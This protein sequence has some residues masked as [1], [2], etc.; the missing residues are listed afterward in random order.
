MNQVYCT[1]CRHFKLLFE[2]ITK[3]IPKN[4]EPCQ[5]CFP[6]E[7][8]DSRPSSERPYYEDEIVQA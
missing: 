1:N 5:H 2:A 7:V 4:P 6:Y 8:E 3:G